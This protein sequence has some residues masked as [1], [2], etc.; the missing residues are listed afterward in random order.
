M[1]FRNLAGFEFPA[2]ISH[3][4]LDFDVI[5]VFCFF[6]PRSGSDTL[7]VLAIFCLDKERNVEVFRN[8]LSGWST[9]GRLK[10]CNRPRW[11]FA[12]KQKFETLVATNFVRVEWKGDRRSDRV[13]WIAPLQLCWHFFVRFLSELVSVLAFAS[14]GEIPISCFRIMLGEIAVRQEIK[15]K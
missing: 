5:F 10:G 3:A 6:V 13:K 14:S 7:P 15:M 4:A 8:W 1:E 11:N 12:L 9:S 2:H